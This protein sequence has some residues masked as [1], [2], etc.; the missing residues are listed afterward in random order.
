MSRFN[1]RRGVMKKSIK[2]LFV[3]LSIV[4]L[5]LFVTN[6][7]GAIAQEN[8]QTSDNVLFVDFMTNYA[9]NVLPQPWQHPKRI[10]ETQEQRAKRVKLII[11]AS[12]AALAE[13]QAVSNWAYEDEALLTATVMKM[14]HESGRFSLAVH[15]GRKRGDSRKSVCLGQIMHGSEDLVGTDF[16]STKRCASEVMRHLVIHQNRC[17]KHSKPGKM[18]VWLIAKVYAGYGTGHSCDGNIFFLLKNENKEPVLDKN[19]QPIKVYWARDR[20]LDWAK[21]FDA[22]TTYKESHVRD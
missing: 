6:K 16:E 8:Q 20:A 7:Q 11:D 19:G 2:N 18:N 9:T 22:Y 10:E 3:V 13:T 14:F 15:D 21:M 1:I 5:T 12:F 17:L 4:V